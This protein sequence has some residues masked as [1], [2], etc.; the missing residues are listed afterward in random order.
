MERSRIRAWLVRLS[1]AALLAA[2][3]VVVPVLVYRGDGYARYRKL[4]DD[5]EEID[6][7]NEALRL[8]NRA[9]KREVKHLRSDPEALTAVARDELGLVKPGEIVIQIE[10]P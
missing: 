7:K 8:E 1:C 6:R 10:K 9:L 2:L 3:L 4:S 5:L